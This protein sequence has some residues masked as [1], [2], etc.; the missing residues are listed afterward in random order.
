MTTPNADGAGRPPLA[1]LARQTL[2]MLPDIVRLFRDVLRD[3]RVPRVAK[4]QAG[5]LLAIGFSP[6]DAIPLIGQTELVA[7]IALA[8]RQL[9]KHTDVAILREHWSGTDEGFRALMLLVETGLRPG[10]MAVRLLT[11]RARRGR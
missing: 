11:G 2:S 9:V 7:A 8:A 1:A 3:P 6:I 4:V 10:R 5:A